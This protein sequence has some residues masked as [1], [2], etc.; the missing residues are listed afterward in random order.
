MWPPT[1]MQT[2]ALK[3]WVG[4]VPRLVA[5]GMLVAVVAGGRLDGS[6]EDEV[7]CATSSG[8]WDGYLYIVRWAM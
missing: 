1:W 4:H 5:A 7:R 6:A 8:W 2:R 3:C